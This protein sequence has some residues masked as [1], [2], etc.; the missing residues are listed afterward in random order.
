MTE[1]TSADAENQDS[2][3]PSSNGFTSDDVPV[4][5]NP[6]LDTEPEIPN[7]E[8]MG[9]NSIPEGAI[10]PEVLEVADESD[11]ILPVITEGVDEP[12]EIPDEITD[13][14][15]DSQIPNI[16]ISDNP[17]ES[18]MNM[19]ETET[20]LD[21]SEMTDELD[22][23]NTMP[24]VIE[25]LIPENNLEDEMLMETIPEM[26]DIPTMFEDPEV[27]LSTSM[28][29]EKMNK[30]DDSMV[31]NFP[32]M[33]EPQQPLE[34]SELPISDETLDNDSLQPEII[35]SMTSMEI[36]EPLIPDIMPGMHPSDM[37]PNMPSVVTSDID[38]SAIMPGNEHTILMPELDPSVMM[39]EMDI[40]LMMPGME[41]LMPGIEPSEE[42]PEM[43]PSINMPEMG[44]IDI[45][46][47]VGLSG[48]MSDINL[49]TDP[50]LDSDNIPV[51]I[52]P[53]E[54]EPFRPEVMISPDGM[55]IIDM[56]KM[57][58][59]PSVPQIPNSLPP[60]SDIQPIEEIIP[61]NEIEIATDVS[62]TETTVSPGV[63]EGFF[64]EG[65]FLHFDGG[66]GYVF[67]F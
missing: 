64:A 1:V 46:P 18:I 45:V 39:P 25:E 53:T 11:M 12:V 5:E 20:N 47:E 54:I 36:I 6:I 37:I 8:D 15:S 29:T 10:V 57:P 23:A 56:S 33:E 26:S 31:S 65:E 55:V 52:M 7:K 34:E 48:G 44:S 3:N 43:D 63:D 40:S 66:F 67:L 49:E 22:L 14:T 41:S 21:V 9:S 62:D 13:E 38:S 24:N 60:E 19:P 42:L 30:E 58:L 32:P 27:F 59:S 61:I 4:E 17:E 28:E 16:S 51:D 50:S 35:P 2:I